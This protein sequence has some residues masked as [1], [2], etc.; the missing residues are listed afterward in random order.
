MINA[1]KFNTVGSIAFATSGIAQ[2][3]LREGSNDL[4]TAF[5][6][7]AFE[8]TAEGLVLRA[9]NVV[10]SIAQKVGPALFLL[11]LAG[12]EAEMRSLGIS[13]KESRIN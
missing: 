3:V 13:V 7:G 4:L 8:E 5:L 10:L 6:Y 2:K 11:Q 9:P 12:L 1:G